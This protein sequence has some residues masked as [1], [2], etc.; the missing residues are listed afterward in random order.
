MTPERWHQVTQ[1]FQRVIASDAASR[2]VL[3]ARLCGDDAPLRSEVDSL[4]AAHD[5]AGPFGD[6]PLSLPLFLEPGTWLGPYR[7]HS[8]LGAGGMGEVYRAADPRLGRDVALKVL[9]LHLTE[10]PARLVMFEQ[11]ARV[12][13][14][15]NHPHI[16]ALYGLEESAGVRALVMELV[17]G[18]ELT[19]LIARGRVPVPTALALARQIA[20]A[21]AA[22]HS[23]GIVHRDLKPANIKVRADGTV[24]LLDFGLAKALGPASPAA[25]GLARTVLPGRTG[26]DGHRIGTAAYMSPEQA[27]GQ[28]ADTRADVWSFGIVLYEMLTGQSPFPAGTPAETLTYVAERDPDISGLP[29]ETPA[30]IRALLAGCL[31]REAGRRLATIGEARRVIE[32]ELASAQAPLVDGSGGVERPPSLRRRLVAA[33]VLLSAGLLAWSLWPAPSVPPPAGASVESIAVLP[34]V[35]ASG[36]AE[37]EYLGQI[38]STVVTR[39]SEL[40]LPNLRVVPW[41]AV[42]RYRD[43]AV[44]PQDVGRALN[45]SAVLVGLLTGEGDG[46]RIEMELVDVERNTLLWSRP[47]SRRLADLLPLHTQIAEDVADQLRPVLSD[48]QRRRVSKRDTDDPKALQHYLKGQGY[49]DR[50]TNDGRALAILNF[51]EAVRLDPRY[52]LAHAALALVYSNQAS[53]GVIPP[54]EAYPRAAA[55]T[56]IALD[57]DPAMAEAHLAAAVVAMDYTRDWAA[58]EASFKRAIAINPEH[59]NAHHW[60]SHFLATQRRFDESLAESRRVLAIDPLDPT[61][62]A[63]LGW[64]H[65]VAGDFER[66]VEQCLNALAFG[67]TWQGHFYLGLAYEQQGRHADAIAQLQQARQVS[68]AN[69][70]SLGALGHAFAA[71]GQPAE[72][73]GV[74]DEFARLKATQPYVSEGYQALVYAG[75][76]D[77]DRTLG[78]LEYA[79]ADGAGWMRDLNIE[80]RYAH[81]RAAPRLVALLQRMG[82]PAPPPGDGAGRR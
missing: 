72:A 17:E 70:A 2:E 67:K 63:H 4:L 22:A 26:T 66:A 34:F 1:V 32:L 62:N 6:A 61:M 69:L 41:S 77:S 50:F 5:A 3:I 39:L 45:V 60:Y 10:D 18:E 47:Y 57:L 19:G 28:P 65:L 53:S 44:S 14:S 37:H 21:L 11:E 71:A 43:Q 59:P 24:K 76:G 58:A 29:P 36:D 55:A 42:Y 13:A 49:Y 46:V 20:E 31:T 80:R 78:W 33:A 12:L 48:A 35:N 82:L 23:Q 51:E 73:Q 15:L 68:P 74:I 81:L 38:A 75:L 56:R 27:L 52:G 79:Y 30:S 9:P 54:R 8:L 7:I 64:S 16:G 40:Q 25:A